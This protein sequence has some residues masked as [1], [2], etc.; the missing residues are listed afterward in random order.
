[1]IPVPAGQSYQEVRG[2][3]RGYQHASP[4]AFNGKYED[5]D[6]PYVDGVSITHGQNPRKHIYTFASAWRF[7]G[8]KVTCPSK[9]FGLRAPE[10]VADSYICDSGFDDPNK[11]YEKI[12]YLNDPLWSDMRENCK[13]QKCSDDYNFCVKLPTPTTDDIELRVCTDESRVNEDIRLDLIE[14]YIK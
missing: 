3:V 2:K 10:F 9:G 7:E 6:G 14:I 12:T 5:I 4:E 11:S 13:D 8:N 1:M